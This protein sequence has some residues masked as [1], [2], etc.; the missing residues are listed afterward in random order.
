MKSCK[1]SLVF[2]IVLLLAASCKSHEPVDILTDYEVALMSDTPLRYYYHRMP[3]NDTTWTDYR[4][5]YENEE[6]FVIEEHFANGLPSS[7]SKYKVK[8]QTQEV[9]EKIHYHLRDSLTGDM[10]AVRA[11]IIRHLQNEPEND[12]SGFSFVDY[13]ETSMGVGLK[14]KTECKY[15]G[16][17]T[18]NYNGRD[19]E[20]VKLEHQF[21]TVTYFKWFPFYFHESQVKGYVIFSKGVGMTW[22]RAEDSE[23]K[24]YSQK[25]LRVEKLS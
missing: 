13:Y 9:V 16:K 8:D 7:R 2:A 10:E 21:S 25:L 23:G 5:I 18:Y 20:S 1:K 17:E 14:L 15:I 3:E 12:Y 19:I 11:D 24:I 4:T 6:K 22:Y